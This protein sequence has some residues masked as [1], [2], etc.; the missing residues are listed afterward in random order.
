MGDVMLIAAGLLF[1]RREIAWAGR[2][3][4]SWCVLWPLQ[5][6]KAVWRGATWPARWSRRQNWLWFAVSWFVY[7]QISLVV[8]GY[9]LN[10]LLDIVEEIQ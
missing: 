6:V 1:W 10:L 5:G 9:V 3:W 8:L 2:Q 4:W 7:S